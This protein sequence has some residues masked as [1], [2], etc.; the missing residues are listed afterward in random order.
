MDKKKP[1]ND[2]KSVSPTP[3]KAPVTLLRPNVKNELLQRYLDDDNIDEI[4]IIGHVKSG[5]Y[6]W[7]HTEIKDA[8]GLMGFILSKLLQIVG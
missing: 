1:P 8:F 7:E 2:E 4:V 5:G 6:T 3:K